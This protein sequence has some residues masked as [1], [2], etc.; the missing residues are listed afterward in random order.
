MF[1][2]NFSS[3]ASKSLSNDLV[4]IQFLLPLGLFSILFLSVN[5]ATGQPEFLALR[6]LLVF[7]IFHTE[8]ARDTRSL[9]SCL[10]SVTP[11][12]REAATETAASLDGQLQAESGRRGGKE[13]LWKGSPRKSCRLLYIS[14]PRMPSELETAME[15][16]IS[17]FHRYALRSGDKDK[18]SKKELKQLLQNELGGPLKTQKYPE[19]VDKIMRGLDKNGD[20]QVSF[21]EFLKLVAAILITGNSSFSEET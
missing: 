8:L 6:V 13:H 10:V 20:G 5:R 16:I 1:E 21:Q 14:G 7:L 2:I 3:V 15:I 11:S 4:L 12:M 18:L 9:V 19:G 17:V